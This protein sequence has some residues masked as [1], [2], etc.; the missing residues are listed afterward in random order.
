ME[1]TAEAPSDDTPRECCNQSHQSNARNNEEETKCCEERED[2][3]RHG[4]VTVSANEPLPLAVSNERARNPTVNSHEGVGRG[5]HR[6]AATESPYLLQHAGNPVN[7]WTWCS[8]AFAEARA[9][10]LP[11]FVSVGYATCHWCHVMERESF[12]NEACAARLNASFIAI[13][14]DREQRPDVDDALMSACQIYTQASEGRASGGWP[15][16]AFLDPSSGF[17]FFIGT[18]FPPEPAWGRA[19]FGQLLDGLSDAW[20]HRRPALVEQSKRIARAVVDAVAVDHPPQL[21]RRECA[22]RAAAQLMRLFDA[23][24]GGFGSAPKFPQPSYLSLVREAGGSAGKTIVHTTLT[25]MALGGVFD[26][27]AGG[28]HRYSVD[29]A[30][31]V[32]HF[33]KM[34]YDNALLVPIYAECA[35]ESGDPFLLQVCERTLEFVDR[36]LSLP[37]G[38]FFCALDADVDHREGAGHVWTP[39]SVTEALESAGVSPEQS[40]EFIGATGLDGD[41]NFRD[42]HHP[43]EAPTW[44]LQM[45]SSQDALNPATG[46][47]LRALHKSRLARAQPMRDEKVL[48][49]WNGLMIE[50]FA[51]AGGALKNPQWIARASTAAEWVMGNLHSA[52]GWQRCWFRG[53]ASTSAALEDLAS[54]G[55]GCAA[56]A[57]VTGDDAWWQRAAV[58]FRDARGEFY[59][60]ESG[61]WHDARG[62]DNLL[63]VRPRSL[64]DGATPSGTTCVVRLMIALA[65]HFDDASIRR[66]L[67]QTLRAVGASLADQPLAMTA[68][69]ALLNRARVLVPSAF[70]NCD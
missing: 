44:V 68:M 33:E 8:E 21:I 23:Q 34:L 13:K 5:G 20:K 64:H 12:A 29:E 16:S 11:I 52:T 51:T 60:E 57:A 1:E 30:W 47:V 53:R 50:G 45:R 66:D 14:V 69:V 36:E 10:D 38:G 67:T 48:L 55:N 62:G 35:A 19:S 39:G 25:K 49:G 31:Q 63:F 37:E 65:A 59:E 42:P 3:R 24:H 56:L 17:P 70:E 9:R 18:Y 2:E 58:L 27:V 61:R 40:S 46:A 28:F 6:L 7:W 32:P 26:Q 54:L 15:L 4:I 41:A 22:E 43:D